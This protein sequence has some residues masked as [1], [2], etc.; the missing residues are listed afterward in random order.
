MFLST[1]HVS[2]HKILSNPQALAICLV[3]SECHQKSI[4][5]NN[6]VS[7]FFFFSQKWV[8]AANLR[9]F[10]AIIK[11]SVTAQCHSLMAEVGEGGGDRAP[12]TQRL[13]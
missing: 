7:F 2:S 12:D 10:P 11:S 1:L 6:L 9:P 8:E 5:M 3:S 4:R 13:G